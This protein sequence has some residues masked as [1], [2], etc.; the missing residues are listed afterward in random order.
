M[1][2]Q[3]QSRW[4]RMDHSQDLLYDFV[5]L[6]ST[7]RPVG[8]IAD[9]LA[10]KQAEREHKT[11]LWHQEALMAYWTFL[12]SQEMGLVGDFNE[13]TV[14]LFRV[15]LRQR[16]NK[17]NTISNRLRSLRAFA[18]WMVET[19]WVKDYP[20]GSLRVP[21]S[22][23][24]EFDLIPD[25][26]RAALFELYSSGTFLGSRNLGML[27]VLSDTG[28]RREEVVN[29]QLKNLDLEAGVLKVYSNK[30]EEWRY[31]P[32]TNEVAGLLRNYLKWRERYF[33]RPSKSRDLQRK[34]RKV[35]GD[36][37][38]PAWNGKVMKPQALGLFLYRASKKIGA[39]IHP[40]LFRH[41]WITRKALDGE[42]PSI[43]RRWAGHKNFAMTDYYFELADKMLG[44]IKPKRSV[45]STI[46]LPGV[47]R[48]GRP[49]KTKTA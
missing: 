25:A 21:Q 16:G 29:L 24:P 43:V 44:A 39:R 3:A 47:R 38:F 49:P 11:Y 13:S 2:A 17:D 5:V 7:S 45:L 26:E 37:L 1:V 48:R 31:L 15:Q 10:K 23:K 36:W 4:R 40:H 42:N 32:L 35:E 18:N 19:G 46:T 30:T 9:F 28:L 12:E 33:S 41:D 27:G 14:N 34:P 6:K 22:V 8:P 20:L